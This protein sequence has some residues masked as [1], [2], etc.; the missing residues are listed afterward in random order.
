LSRQGN[1]A[2]TRISNLFNG[3]KMHALVKEAL[4]LALLERPVANL[5]NIPNW[6][7]LKQTGLS[8]LGSVTTNPHIVVA[9]LVSDMIL[10]PINAATSL[11]FKA[12]TFHALAVQML[13]VKVVKLQVFKEICLVSQSP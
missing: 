13:I 10:E 5:P 4:L 11:E 12:T 2:A 6:L 8:C 9:T 3:K 1:V 7:T